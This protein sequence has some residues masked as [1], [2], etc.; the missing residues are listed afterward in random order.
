MK[1]SP[2][3]I[4]NQDF[5]KSVRGFDKDEVQAFLG[6]LSYE[7]EIL[8][9][10][11]EQ[12]KKDLDAA[13]SRLNEFRKIEK[14]LQ[15]TLLKAQESSTKALES[16]R[17]QSTLMVKEA[18]IKASQIVEKARESANEIRNAVINLREERDLVVARLKSIISSQAHLLEMK[19]E[20]AGDERKPARTIEGA[21]KIEINIDEIVNKIL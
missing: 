8:Q 12:L 10:E 3:N 20:N 15:N 19:V 16:T 7:F 4:K 2:I 11:N 18:E 1:F 21:K 14:N 5:R 6:K 13:N 9:Q 17:K